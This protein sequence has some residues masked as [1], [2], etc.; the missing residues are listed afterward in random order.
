MAAIV[1]LRIVEVV[2]LCCCGREDV[3]KTRTGPAAIAGPV[4]DIYS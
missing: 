1:G 3:L 2:A 4:Q